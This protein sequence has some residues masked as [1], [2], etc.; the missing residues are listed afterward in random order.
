MSVKVEV[1]CIGNEL[2]I[3]KINNTNSNW[4][5]KQVT[6][7]GANLTRITVIRDL[8]PEIGQTIKQTM[9]HKPQ[10]IIITGGLGPTFDDKTFQ[11]IAQAF[12]RPLQ[13]DP[14]ALEMVK[15]RCIEYEK[16]HH[17][18]NEIELTPPR[19]KMATFP[20]GTEPVNNPIGTAPGLCFEMSGT[21]LFALPG[22]PK[23]MKA[24]FSETIA[25]LI[26]QKT[27]TNI[28]CEKS[29]F[30]EKIYESRLA[31]LIDRIMT[32]NPGVYIKS[33]PMHAKTKPLVELHFTIMANKDLKPSEKLLKAAKELA[34]LIEMDG[35]I[36]AFR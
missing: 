26:K 31:P 12:N 36:V 28:F 29:I 24:I 30:A 18:Q 35:G 33:H 8:V 2:L 20:Q 19:L 22:V 6:K 15:Q 16:R 1:I 4:L 23:E 5:S 14:K 34:C 10:F 17:Q 27:R 32:D 13:I 3:G 11:G 7:L 25:P 21:V 9:T